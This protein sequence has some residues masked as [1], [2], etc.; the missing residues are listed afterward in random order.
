VGAINLCHLSDVN[1]YLESGGRLERDFS[2]SLFHCT[3][4]TTLLAVQTTS[5]NKYPVAL[6]T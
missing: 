1:F 3:T 6:S 2:G 4:I 5:L